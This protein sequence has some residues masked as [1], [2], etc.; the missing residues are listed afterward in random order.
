MRTATILAAAGL[1]FGLSAFSLAAD[2][3]LSVLNG[4]PSS[5]SVPD[6]NDSPVAFI[7]AP[8]EI[9]N[10]DI[11]TVLPIIDLNNRSLFVENAAL[12]GTTGVRNRGRAV[13]A[14]FDVNN[15][16]PPYLQ[17]Q[18]NLNYDPTI[19]DSYLVFLNA[20]EAA[21]IDTMAEL[22][23]FIASGTAG[24]DFVQIFLTNTGFTT[25][26]G[27]GGDYTDADIADVVL[28]AGEL[29]FLAGDF[30][31]IT[32]GS[33]GSQGSAL[34]FELGLLVFSNGAA[35]G[36]DIPTEYF[37]VR[38]S[39]R[40]I[41]PVSAT[42]TEGDV[43]LSIVAD[44]PLATDGA[45]TLVNYDTDP[46]MLTSEAFRVIPGGVGPSQTLNEF[47]LNLSSPRNAIGFGIS[48]DR[49]EI[50]DIVFDAPIDAADAPALLNATIGF[51]AEVA[52]GRVYSFAGEDPRP[53]LTTY[54]P[55]NRQ[56]CPGVGNDADANDDLVIDF[57]DLNIV[58]GAFGQTGANVPGDANGDGVIDFSDL[59]AVLSS[60]GSNCF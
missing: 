46:T 5:E 33:G 7:V 21:N 35:A 25:G 18:A 39:P 13:M 34:A 22:D 36:D 14:V 59:N 45:R 52:N 15:G 51:A 17:V 8:R 19:A 49:R 58:L 48:G 3:P 53:E 31:N 10:S 60:Y 55:V 43:L 40:R 2:I 9:L 44:L 24:A 27:P 38:N 57:A 1:S 4:G 32:P 11:P 16:N 26:S 12:P 50:L 56:A 29:V 30:I 20:D 47:L 28:N 37:C 54:V 6:D 41:A 23:A 42:L